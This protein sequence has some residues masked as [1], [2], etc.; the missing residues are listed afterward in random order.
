MIKKQENISQVPKKEAYVRITATLLNSWANIWNCEDYVVESDNDTI[1]YEDKVALAREKATQE[2]IDLLN[3]KPIPDNEYMQRGREFED[4]V[5]SGKDDEFSPIVDNGAFQ[6]LGTK[7]V[8]IAGVKVLLYGILDVLKAAR[9]NDIKRVTKYSYPKYKKS[10][11]HP[12][13][14][15]LFPETLDFTYLVRD[16][17]GN[18]HYENYIRENCVDIYQVVA[19]FIAYLKANDL[20]DILVEKWTMYV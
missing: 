19:T 5:C 20:F 17:R 7:K 9:I 13:Y 1:S 16:D 14:L 4:L 15:E 11:Q 12:L 6:V 18:S 2:F 10:L 8:V 3:R